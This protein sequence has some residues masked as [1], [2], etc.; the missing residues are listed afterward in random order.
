MKEIKCP[1]CGNKEFIEVKD[2]L[3]DC[4]VHHQGKCYYCSE[5]G[6]VMWFMEDRVKDNK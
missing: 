1:V 2:T 4:H 5:C 6:Y 3:T